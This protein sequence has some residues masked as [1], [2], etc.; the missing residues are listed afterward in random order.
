M[1][2]PEPRAED[3]EDYEDFLD[4]KIAHG[5]EKSMAAQQPPAEAPVEAPQSPSPQ[6]EPT[7]RIE[8]PYLK[9]PEIAA[10]IQAEKEKAELFRDIAV[11]GEGSLRDA[12]AWNDPLFRRGLGNKL[13]K[14]NESNEA[15]VIVVPG[16]DGESGELEEIR[17]ENM[18]FFKFDSPEERDSVLRLASYS[19]GDYF[20]QLWK[21]LK[22]AGYP[23]ERGR[24]TFH[25]NEESLKEEQ[26]RH[27]YEN[28][29]QAEF[30]KLRLEEGGRRW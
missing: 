18:M 19:S 12:P 11:L 3:F 22:S 5:V 14:W 27:R 15:N 28:L 1:D 16:E 4:A 24:K 29:T 6:L 23:A 20:R 9:D 13:R 7:S 2:E 8:P 30:E 21:A 26:H 25:E 10:E 17:P